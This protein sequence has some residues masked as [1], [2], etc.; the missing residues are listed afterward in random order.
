MSF[1]VNGFTP[2]DRNPDASKLR[3]NKKSVNDGVPAY[4]RNY[5]R[6]STF[7]DNGSGQPVP[8]GS[9]PNYEEEKTRSTSIGNKI[10]FN[11]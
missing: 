7:L 6:S 5:G 1:N 4:R 3:Q 11:G 9:K 8:E 2:Y 10:D